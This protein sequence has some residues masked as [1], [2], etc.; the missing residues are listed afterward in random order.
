MPV[1]MEPFLIVRNLNIRIQ[2]GLI[3]CSPIHWKNK[4]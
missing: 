4:G 1:G 3:D 2:V